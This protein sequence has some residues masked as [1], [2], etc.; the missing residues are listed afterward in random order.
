MSGKKSHNKKAHPAEGKVLPILVSKQ[1]QNIL[2]PAIAEICEQHGA[3]LIALELRGSKERRIVEIYVDKPEG[4][5]LD[6]CGNI[7]DSIGE[8]L[9]STKAF[10]G[11]YRLDVSSPGVERPLVHRWQYPR[12]IGRLLV[13]NFQDGSTLKGRLSATD[14]D[15]VTL[16]HPGKGG[17]SRPINRKPSSSSDKKT[18]GNG[19]GQPS[20]EEAEPIFPVIIPFNTIQR[21]AVELEL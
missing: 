2:Q 16:E 4:I 8:M 12:N 9:E 3:Y 6:E 5:S 10:P 20:A 17:K 14:S 15:T 7:S 11:A 21:A 13:I 1:D 19:K 18:S